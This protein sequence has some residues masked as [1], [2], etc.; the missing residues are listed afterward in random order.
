[1]TKLRIDPAT[2]QDRSGNLKRRLGKE[3]NQYPPAISAY[4]FGDFLQLK[5]PLKKLLKVVASAKQVEAFMAANPPYISPTPSRLEL[6][7]SWSTKSK[8]ETLE[9]Y[10]T[11]IESN[12]RFKDLRNKVFQNLYQVIIKYLCPS[13]NTT[14]IAFARAFPDSIPM[15]EVE[16]LVSVK[17]FIDKVALHV[18][19]HES[20]ISASTV[21]SVTYQSMFRRADMYNFKDLEW[22]VRKIS[23][24][25]AIKKSNQAA[26]RLATL[27]AALSANGVI[28]RPDSRF[29]KEYVNCNVCVDLEEVVAV[30]KLTNKL[31]SHGHVVW[32]NLHH[33]VEARLCNQVFTTDPRPTNLLDVGEKWITAVN[34][35]ML[36]RS[37]N[38]QVLNSYYSEDE[39]WDHRW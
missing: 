25:E 32:S 2:L 16:W 19:V 33:T 14:G 38:V 8:A 10:R 28:Y 36:S 13:Y 22:T 18:S 26:S 20:E 35:I 6:F 9:R 3:P 27:Q 11:L 5:H 30:L 15:A 7:E 39:E 29:A 23:E 4:I 12:I 31:F 24:F 17:K 1:M 21:K 37:F 34:E